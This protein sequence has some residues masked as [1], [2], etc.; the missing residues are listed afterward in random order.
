LI[1][2]VVPEQIVDDDD[3]AETVIGVPN[4]TVAVTVVVHPLKSVTRQ[5]Y[6][7]GASGVA[8]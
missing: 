4:V 7:P 8:V 2:A 6:T 1:V 5:V 3:V